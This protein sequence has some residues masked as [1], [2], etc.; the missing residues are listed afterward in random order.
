MSTM[1]FTTTTQS[2]KEEVDS[3]IRKLRGPV[4]RGDEYK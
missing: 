3:V 1:I 4:N 2:R